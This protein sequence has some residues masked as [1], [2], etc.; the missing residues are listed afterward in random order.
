MDP[1]PVHRLVVGRRSSA[2]K[3]WVLCRSCYEWE[4][5]Q[6]PC[7]ARLGQ[8]GAQKFQS[9]TNSSDTSSLLGDF[10][11]DRG[12]WGTVD[13]CPS[14]DISSTV[15]ENAYH[16]TNSQGQCAGPSPSPAPP[17][18]DDSSVPTNDVSS[19]LATLSPTTDLSFAFWVRP[20]FSSLVARGRRLVF[21]EIGTNTPPIS[22]STR[23]CADPS[24]KYDLQIANLET[25]GQLL[26]A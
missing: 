4:G 26:R 6:L 12:N 22:T 15:F 18:R 13:K 3:M 8:W 25:T 5:K 2:A 20:S 9:C 7:L 1:P 23:T 10:T 19:L 11:Y 17:S 24:R 14:V 21:L 16:G